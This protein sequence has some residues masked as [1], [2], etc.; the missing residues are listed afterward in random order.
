MFL[1]FMQRKS[2]DRKLDDSD[3]GD[4][5]T[6]SGLKEMMQKHTK[7]RMAMM[8]DEDEDRDKLEEEME[9]VSLNHLCCVLVF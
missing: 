3:E 7:E 6:N 9:A 4:D 8:T 2:K 1:S 5:A